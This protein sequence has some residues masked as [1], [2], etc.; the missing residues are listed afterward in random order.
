MKI[1]IHCVHLYYLCVRT[2]GNV[3]GIFLKFHL[4]TPV[5]CTSVKE[6]VSGWQTE[7]APSSSAWQEGSQEGMWGRPRCPALTDVLSPVEPVL[8]SDLVL[9]LQG[10]KRAAVVWAQSCSVVRC[11]VPPRELIAL[12]D[13][14]SCVPAG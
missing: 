3:S 7:A 10:I 5:T 6:G 9:V 13:A 2:Q 1:I 8:L 11:P 12:H 4:V 14:H